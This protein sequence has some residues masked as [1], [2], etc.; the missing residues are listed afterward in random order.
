MHN[1][2][3]KEENESFEDDSSEEDTFKEDTSKE[4][5]SMVSTSEK[6]IRFPVTT[7]KP[8]PTVPF[9]SETNIDPTCLRTLCG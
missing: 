3:S 9:I 1:L 5:T 6:P 2:Q 4:D 7:R 8:Q